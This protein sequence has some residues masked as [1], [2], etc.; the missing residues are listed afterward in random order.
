MNKK[1]FTL[2]EVISVIT[3]LA[4]IMIIV[5]PAV[6]KQLSDSK[7]A[8]VKMNVKN[9]EESALLLVTDLNT[10]D[11]EALDILKTENILS[12]VTG[13]SYCLTTR[14]AL[15]SVDGIEVSMDV[16]VKYDYLTDYDKK[17]S[18]TVK[19]KIKNANP[20]AEGSSITCG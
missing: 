13:E 5:I 6:A 2:V 17:C 15:G 9:A 16:L 7:S 20:L 3:V 14:N 11:K 12:E 8:L 10:C 4:I 19:L 18:G 1:G